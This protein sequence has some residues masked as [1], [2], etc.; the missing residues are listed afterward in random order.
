MLAAEIS[1]TQARI[2]FAPNESLWAQR[3]DDVLKFDFSGG[4]DT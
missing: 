1:A 3:F 4:D 2:K